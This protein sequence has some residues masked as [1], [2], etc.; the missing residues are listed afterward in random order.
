VPSGTVSPTL[1]GDV[2]PP[3]ASGATTT[4]TYSPTPPIA[5]T[6][7]APTGFSLINSA[8]WDF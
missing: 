2:T 1:A 4:P 5:P 6:G 8:I 3:A 7:P